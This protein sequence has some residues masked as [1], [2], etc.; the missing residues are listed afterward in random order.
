VV[1]DEETAGDALYDAIEAVAKELKASGDPYASA[2]ALRDLAWAWQAL[3]GAGQPGFSIVLAD[4][5]ADLEAQFARRA[6]AERVGF[7]QPDVQD[8]RTGQ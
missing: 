1:A 2:P 8:R 5:V 7:D 6:Y 3:V 4:R